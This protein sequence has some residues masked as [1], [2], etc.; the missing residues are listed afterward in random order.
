M[1][2]TIVDHW[3]VFSYNPDEIMPI[4]CGFGHEL[5]EKN[6][7]KCSS[8]ISCKMASFY[9][10]QKKMEF[11]NKYI[12]IYLTF[13]LAESDPDRHHFNFKRGVLYIDGKKKCDVIDYK[14]YNSLQIENFCYDD[15][16]VISV[17]GDVFC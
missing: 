11:K 13:T 1:N 14:S 7:V 9:I 2:T 4:I 15:I 16:S 10:L 6:V 8:I 12:E 17:P 3:L 5:K